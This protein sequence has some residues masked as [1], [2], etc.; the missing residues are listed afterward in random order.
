MGTGNSSCSLLCGEKATYYIAN[1]LT[2]S[3]CASCKSASGI[4]QSGL[5]TCEGCLLVFLLLNNESAGYI[6]PIR[7]RPSFSK[8]SLSELSSFIP[9]S[10]KSMIGTY[11]KFVYKSIIYYKEQCISQEPIILSDGIYIGQWNTQL[12]RHGRGVFISK[13]EWVYQGYWRNNTMTGVGRIFYS[14][15]RYYEGGLY[16]NLYSGIGTLISPPDD[17][18]QGNWIHGTKYGT[19]VEIHCDGTA[20]EG[21]HQEGNK[22]G[23]GKLKLSDGRVFEGSFLDDKLQ[24]KCRIE[25]PDGRSYEGEVKNCKMEGKGILKWP[26]GR[27]YDG[28]FLN[29]Q[30]HEKGVLK[31]SDGSKYEGEWQN[32]RQHGRGRIHTHTGISREVI[33]INGDLITKSIH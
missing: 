18:Y 16:N 13:K 23:Y 11:G 24:G 22:H 8:L 5:F 1:G 28:S 19:G 32:G 12:Q 31:L 7:T 15:G 2:N 33:Y 14:D 26:D 21:M 10:V 4:N 29:N 20:Y 9:D 17:K 6:I 25:W 30:M 27:L 3:S